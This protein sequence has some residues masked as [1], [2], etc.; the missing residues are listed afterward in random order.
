MSAPP[1]LSD[2]ESEALL[3]AR[4]PELFRT[5]RIARRFMPPTGARLVATYE[6]RPGEPARRMFFSLPSPRRSRR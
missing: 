6:I 1:K 4:F 2:E 3:R 5:R